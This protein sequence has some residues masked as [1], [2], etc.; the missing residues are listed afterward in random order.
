MSYLKNKME[1]ISEKKKKDG[2][3]KFIRCTAHRKK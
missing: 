1:I 3:I 2:A